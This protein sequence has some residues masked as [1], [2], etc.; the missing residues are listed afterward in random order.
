MEDL[1]VVEFEAHAVVDLV[2]AE[3]DV[4]LVDVVP[5]L[6]ADLIGARARLRRHQLLQVSDCVVV[7]ALHPNLLPQP[8]VQHHLYHLRRGVIETGEFET[9]VLDFLFK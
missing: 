3:G 4:V 8:I 9:L 6:D 2:V 1:V 7:V 5:L